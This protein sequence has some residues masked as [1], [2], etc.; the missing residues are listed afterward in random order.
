MLAYILAVIAI[1]CVWLLVCGGADLLI[2]LVLF[3]GMAK[4]TCAENPDKPR[5]V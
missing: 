3:P 1:Y 4:P 5:N 2:E